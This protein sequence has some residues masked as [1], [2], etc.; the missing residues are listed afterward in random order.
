MDIIL[1][2]LI[3]ALAGWLASK[4]MRLESNALINILLG[5]VGGMLGSY[6][7]GLAN[8]SLEMGIAGEVLVAFIGAIVL[9]VAY[10][11]LSK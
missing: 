11:V 9:V 4:V 8:V 5:V 3:G 1:S 7:L 6:L 2:I 10:K